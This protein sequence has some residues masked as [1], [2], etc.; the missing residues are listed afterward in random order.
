MTK[1]DKLKRGQQAQQLQLVRRAIGDA[2]GV[3][4]FSS[5]TGQGLDEARDV[6]S[7]WLGL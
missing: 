5:E 1:A 6:V 2:A 7:G 3:Q 4:L